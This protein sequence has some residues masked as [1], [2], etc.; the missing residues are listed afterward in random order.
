VKYL[1]STAL[2]FMLVALCAPVLAQQRNCKFLNESCDNPAPKARTRADPRL[3]DDEHL[4]RCLAD[5]VRRNG[6]FVPEG[7]STAYV[8]SRSDMTAMCR[9]AIKFK[10]YSW[11]YPANSDVEANMRCCMNGG[12][13]RETCETN[14]AAARRSKMN[15]D[16]CYFASRTGEP[17]PAEWNVPPGCT[18]GTCMVTPG[19]CKSV[20]YTDMDRSLIPIIIASMHESM[21]KY[22]SSAEQFQAVLRVCFGAN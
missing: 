1:R 22:P 8:K 20:G 12:S 3:T 16:F 2:V 7:H 17:P 18:E 13:D 5:Y 4:R 15:I 11:S 19:Y 10:N 6:P 14:I 9:H 21:V